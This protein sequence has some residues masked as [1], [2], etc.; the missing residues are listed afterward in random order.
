MY[1]ANVQFSSILSI[2]TCRVKAVD[3]FPLRRSFL[4]YLL[5][6][7]ILFFSF[8]ITQSKFHIFLRFSDSTYTPA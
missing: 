7:I 5:H 4:F 1:I 2:R 6:I 3:V 8:Q